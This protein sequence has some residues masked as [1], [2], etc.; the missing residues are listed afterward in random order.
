MRF[1]RCAWTLPTMRSGAIWQEALTMEPA[2]LG[3][4]MATQKFTSGSAARPGCQFGWKTRSTF[5][6]A[7]DGWNH[8]LPWRQRIFSGSGSVRLILSSFLVTITELAG[9]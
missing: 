2:A 4:Q 6:A 5:P 8:L 7:K 3:L 1:L 9:E